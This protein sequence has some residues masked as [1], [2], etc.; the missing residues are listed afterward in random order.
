MADQLEQ[1]LSRVL[2]YM[3]QWHAKESI[4][5]Y[6]DADVFKDKFYDEVVELMENH[7]PALLAALSD[8]RRLREAPVL[9][10]RD[11]GCQAVPFR[12]YGILWAPDGDGYIGTGGMRAIG[13]FIGKRV[14]IVPLDQ[15][16]E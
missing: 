12:P 14:A 5:H 8:Q 4:G 2:D 3:K 9:E 13:Q 10:V 15:E 1:D 6:N 16:G 7:G 11:N